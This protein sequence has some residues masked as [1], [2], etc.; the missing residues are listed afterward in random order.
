MDDAWERNYIA[1][2]TL[3]LICERVTDMVE[4]QEYDTFSFLG[5]DD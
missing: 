1:R 5:D 2:C 3:N 4:I